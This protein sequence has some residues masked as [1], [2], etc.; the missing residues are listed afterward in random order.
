[1]D[2]AASQHK[3]SAA[4][5]DRVRS[6]LTA[7]YMSSESSAEESD[8]GSILRVK[9]VVWLKKKYRDAFHAIDKA[10]YCSHKHSRDK[11]KRRVYDGD[12]TRSQPLHVPRFAIK[13]EFRTEN[14]ADDLN[15][16]SLSISESASPGVS[17]DLLSDHESSPLD[18][19]DISSNSE[20]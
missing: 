5:K 10:Y 15:D 7:D 3:W 6:L 8:G 1:M 14:S 20:Q 4:H 11:L 17:S 19:N 16:S 13:S 12:T 2:K 9:K 18:L